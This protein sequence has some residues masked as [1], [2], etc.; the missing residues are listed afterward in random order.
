MGWGEVQ[1]VVGGF[2]YPIE[3]PWPAIGKVA[4]WAPDHSVSPPHGEGDACGELYT[5]LA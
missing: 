5:Y 2:R 4:Q 3:Q 1:G